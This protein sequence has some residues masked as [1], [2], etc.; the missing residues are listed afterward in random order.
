MTKKTNFEYM[1][2]AADFYRTRNDEARKE[3]ELLKAM[4]DEA[5]AVFQELKTYEDGKDRYFHYEINKILE[6]W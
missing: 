5:K 3:I 2:E 1:V 4:L 6:G